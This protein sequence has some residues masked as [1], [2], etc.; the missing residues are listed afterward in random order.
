MYREEQ[1]RL[2]AADTERQ[3]QE[4]LRSRRR[5]SFQRD[6]SE[7]VLWVADGRPAATA[8]AIVS[9]GETAMRQAAVM[10]DRGA[11]AGAFVQAEQHAR[12]ELDRARQEYRIRPPLKLGLSK[13]TKKDWLV[14]KESMDGLDAKVFE[15]ATLR[16][17]ATADRLAQEL[18]LAVDRRIRLNE[19]LSTTAQAA[20][21]AARTGNNPSTAG[22]CGS[23]GG[24]REL[25]V[26][27]LHDLDVATQAAL[28]ESASL[29]VA[30]MT[31]DNLTNA[32]ESLRRRSMTCFRKGSRSSSNSPT[33]S[34]RSLPS[35][36]VKKTPPTSTSPNRMN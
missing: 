32:A 9:R 14:Y 12:R 5:R 35:W 7:R 34:S 36:H 17:T 24:S 13:S 18:D 3:R 2:Q 16:L 15:P 8:E 10:R 30:T 23:R 27:T 33:A 20:R 11:A 1:Q 22:R 25:I 19:G 6:L 28:A 31:D 4:Q 26:A 29:D 21:S